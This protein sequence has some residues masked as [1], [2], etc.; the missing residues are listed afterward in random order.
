[1]C[2]QG[3]FWMTQVME[4]MK[5]LEYDMYV[6]VDTIRGQRPCGK[7]VTSKAR[8]TLTNERCEREK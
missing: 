2:A 6:I 7:R 5:D 1:M 8:L 3:F 4:G